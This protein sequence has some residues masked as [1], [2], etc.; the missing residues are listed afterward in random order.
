[1]LCTGCIFFREAF[2][3]KLKPEKQFSQIL[4]LAER[5]RLN[6]RKY[7]VLR[8]LRS[9]ALFPIL[10]AN[11]MVMPL[12]TVK[13][14]PAVVSSTPQNSTLLADA[15]ANK[16]SV[17]DE[18]VAKINA[19][20]G[21]KGLPLAGHG[22]ELVTAADKNGL[23]YTLLA[24]IAMRESTGGKFACRSA[25]AP[26]N[27]WGWGSCSTGFDSVD[28]AIDKISAHLGGNIESTARYYK[29]KDVEGILATFNPPKIVRQYVS[30]V[31]AIMQTIK[32]YP[33]DIT[34]NQTS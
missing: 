29:G 6:M 14:P 34:P 17:H 16:Q 21:D 26:N 13:L 24:A 9:F 28:Q 7:N 15:P 32:D 2:K 23:D 8:S 5:N 3:C 20:F 11:L 22:E 12:G 1:M 27:Y 18:E 33:V 31:K 4:S 25:L 10:T 19:Y 30:Q